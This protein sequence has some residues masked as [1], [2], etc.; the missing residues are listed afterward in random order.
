MV[1]DFVLPTFPLDHVSTLEVG[2]PSYSSS[3]SSSIIIFVVVVIVKL[4]QD[5]AQEEGRV[6]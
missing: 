3:S 4:G 6:G 5:A 1:L 2:R